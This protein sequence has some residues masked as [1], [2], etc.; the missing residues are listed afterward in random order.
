MLERLHFVLGGCVG[1]G[2][3]VLKTATALCVKLH[4]RDGRTS[5]RWSL[6]L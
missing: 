4:L 1:K 2:T 5:L 6:T 3:Q